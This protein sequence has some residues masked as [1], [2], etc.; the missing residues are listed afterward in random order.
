MSTSAVSREPEPLVPI[1][2]RIRLLD[3]AVRSCILEALMIQHI[4]Q[5]ACL[6]LALGIL[7]SGTLGT[8]A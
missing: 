1:D 5:L 2:H 4:R 7:I 6:I 3:G 8:T